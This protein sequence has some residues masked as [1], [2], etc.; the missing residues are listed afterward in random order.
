MI[1]MLELADKDLKFSNLNIKMFKD[2]NIIRNN[3]KI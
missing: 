3:C 1:D 2:V